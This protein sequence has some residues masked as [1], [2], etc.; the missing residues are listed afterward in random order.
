M[1]LYIYTID[2]MLFKFIFLSQ[3]SALHLVWHSS[4]YRHYMHVKKNFFRYTLV[5]PNKS[6]HKRVDQ[7]DLTIP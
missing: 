1:A 3:Y 4:K 5:A 7:V 6:M 2:Q